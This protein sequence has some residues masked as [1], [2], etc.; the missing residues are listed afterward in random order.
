MDNNEIKLLQDRITE[1]EKAESRYKIAGDL[2]SKIEL[3]QKAILNNIPD[4]AW[5]KDKESKFIVVNEAFGRAC[6]VKPEELIGKTDLDIWPSELAQKYRLDDQEVMKTG[7]RKCVE[8]P[9]ADKEGKIQWLETIKT[10]IYNDKGEVIGTTGIARDITER[11]RYEE[12]LREAKGES[13]IRVKIRT[14]ELS[15]INEELKQKINE[16]DKLSEG[17]RES[18]HFLAGIFSSIQDGICVL[19]KEMNIVR[20]NPKMEEWY[21]H[22]MPL[23]GK[24]VTRLIIALISLAI[25]ARVLKLFKPEKLLMR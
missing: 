7:K 4:I 23:V 16:R 5:L 15:K 17:L 24:N 19:D 1:L 3:Q 22:N 13:E 11:K 21:A 25:N 9:L 2:L 14:A 20:I 8:E 6:G 12:R 10:A 18:E